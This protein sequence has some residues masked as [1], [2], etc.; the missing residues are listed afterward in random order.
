MIYVRGADSTIAE[1]LSDLHQIHP[2]LRGEQM[3]DDGEKYLFCTGLIRPKQSIDQSAEEIAET[4]KI[5]VIDI[6]R[7]CDRL[8]SINPKARICVTGSESAFKGSFD[9]IYAASKAALHRY[10]ETK[11]LKCPDQQ[12]VC[13][14]PTCILNTGMNRQRNADGVAALER[15][16]LAHPKQRW[17]Q[18]MEVARMIHFLLCVDAG[19]TTNVVIRMGGGEHCV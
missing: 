9:G 18:P 11:R 14:A 19:Y 16:R 1:A 12:L 7:E 5:N 4:L 6:I 17:L 15:R 8:I 3:P 2:V 13:V 10:V